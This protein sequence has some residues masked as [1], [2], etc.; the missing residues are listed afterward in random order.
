MFQYKTYIKYCNNINNNVVVVVCLTIFEKR[1]KNEEKC[2]ARIKTKSINVPFVYTMQ[3]YRMY[4]T[5][6]KGSFFYI[7][8]E[9]LLAGVLYCI[10]MYMYVMF[11][12]CKKK[13][14][15]QPNQPLRPYNHFPKHKNVIKRLSNSKS[16]RKKRVE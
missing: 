3:L 2:S 13:C 12:T 6:G 11:C 14:A 9:F 5:P 16:K 1:D 4:L 15:V 7:V 8:K 10:N